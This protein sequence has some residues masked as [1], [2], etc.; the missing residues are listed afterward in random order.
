M[1]AAL[2]TEE[3]EAIVSQLKDDC[4]VRTIAMKLAIMAQERGKTVELPEQYQQFASV[5]SK[6]ESQC[7]PPKR[8]WDHAI[9]FKPGVPDAIGCTVYPMTQAED[10]VLDD[11]L[12]EQL[13][14]GYIRPSISPY[15][16]VLWPYCQPR[17]IGMAGGPHDHLLPA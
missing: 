13:V 16:K 10:D 8:L 4:Q 15:V 14:K 7:F 12:D 9:D 2:R 11:W 17:S 3:K 1:I 6:E 5:F